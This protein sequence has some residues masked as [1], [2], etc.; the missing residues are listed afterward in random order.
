MNRDDPIALLRALDPADEKDV[1]ALVGRLADA[2]TPIRALAQRPPRSGWTRRRAAWLVVAAAAVAVTL[3]ALVADPF[4]RSGAISSAQAKAQVARALD[5]AG[6]W[7]VTRITQYGG[8]GRGS[9]TPHWSKPTSD[10]LWHAPDGRLVITTSDPSGDTST[11]LYA[12]GERRSYDS[13]G[14]TLTIHRFVRAADLRDE[15]RTYLPSSAADLY[16]AAYRVGKVRLA[17]I[18][19]VGGRR[20]YR[21]AFEWLGSRY[22]LVFDAQRQVPISSESRTPNGPSSAKGPKRYFFTRVRYTAYQRVQPGP[23]LDRHLVLPP[24]PAGARTV[25]EH[26]IVVPAPVVGASATTLVTG[27]IARYKSL[28]ADIKPAHARYAIVQ[29]IPGGGVAALARMPGR[30]SHLLCTA[31]AEF[32]HPGGEARLTSAGCG[33]AGGGYFSSPS[34][35]GRALIVAGSVPHARALAFNFAG[36]KVVKVAMRDGSFLAAPALTLFQ[37]PVTLV[38]TKADGTVVRRPWPLP[39]PFGDFASRLTG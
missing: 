6:G 2:G 38:I 16:R 26:P 5:L 27:I 39:L 8:E 28:G 36:G 18:E 32:A 24:I 3:A 31:V 13:H 14:E 12:R 23:V 7:H 35:N 17:G 34:Q 1:D 19:T 29:A 11:W 33:G 15:M 30:N 21:L 4:S 22:T 37:G 10:D 9:P 20:V 25:Q